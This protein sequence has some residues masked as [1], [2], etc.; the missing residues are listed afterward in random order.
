[1]RQW[2]VI[3]TRPHAENRA[4]DHLERQGFH[5]YLPRFATTRRHARKVETVARPLFPRYMFIDLD[6]QA[7]RWRTVLSTAG[8]AGLVMA[9]GQPSP[10]PDGIVE[11]IQ[12]REDATGLIAIGNTWQP[13]QK[14]R[15]T[16]G[17]FSTVDAIFDGLDDQQ[18]V[19]VL[20]DLM[21]RNIRIQLDAALVAA[22]N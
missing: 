1:M 19:V 7:A 16:S 17:P 21:G 11:N 14:I 10:V 20:F 18:R 22:P 5:A 12:A 2:Y 8:V 15:I 13:G 6:L 9:A 3:H 4:L